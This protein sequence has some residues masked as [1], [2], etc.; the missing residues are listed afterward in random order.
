VIA[1]HVATPEY[2][3]AQ[4]A[5]APIRKCTTYFLGAGFSRSVGLPNTAE[6]LT[7]VHGL[8]SYYNLAIDRQ[9]REAYK[10][11]FPEESDT[12]VPDVVEF[13]SVLSAN[14]DVSRGMP[15]AFRHPTLLS[16]LRFVI[17]RRL[18][19]R[20]RE[21][22]VPEHGWASVNAII[23]PGSVIITSN[24]DVFVEHYARMINVP[25]RLGGE[26]SSEHVTLLKLHGSIDWTRSG[27]R[28]SDASDDD[29][30]ALREVQNATHKRSVAIDGEEILR[31]KA[32]ENLN[33]CWQFIK[34]RTARPLMITMSLGKTSAMVP[35]HFLWDDAYYALSATRNLRIVGYSLPA[36]DIEIR[37]LLRAGIARGSQKCNVLV[38]NPET[39]VHTRVRNQVSRSAS[40]DFRAFL[41][42]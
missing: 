14:E 27:D 26:P 18:C 32:V 41:P 8:A 40:S 15:G 11:F 19:E 42:Q 28:R 7:Q 36:D 35:I 25:L 23:K 1:A 6:L 38:M 13:F 37:T 4:V 29:F 22:D 34:A 12:F 2:A 20:M 39:A 3:H 16:D 9:L 24:W 21:L 30:A 33:R 5:R 17:A 31:I 10:Y